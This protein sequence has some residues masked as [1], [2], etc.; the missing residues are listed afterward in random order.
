MSGGSMDYVYSRVQ[1]IEFDQSTPERIAFA[2]HLQLVAAALR[3]IEWEDSGDTGPEATKLA[4][5]S[6]LRGVQL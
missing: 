4:I 6:C 5:A 3:A 2:A 1:A